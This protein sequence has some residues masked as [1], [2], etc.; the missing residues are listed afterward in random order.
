MFLVNI[1]ATTATTIQN[2]LKIIRV[3]MGSEIVDPK[4]DNMKTLRICQL[5]VIIKTSQENYSSRKTPN[6][7]PACAVFPFLIPFYP[8]SIFV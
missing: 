8:A 5:V 7:V 1:K 2:C 3:E 4:L 6:Y